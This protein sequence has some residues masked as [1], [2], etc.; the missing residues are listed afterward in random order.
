MKKELTITQ[1]Q[2]LLYGVLRI[3]FCGDI[4]NVLFSEGEVPPFNIDDLLETLPAEAQLK[5]NFDGEEHTVMSKLNIQRFNSNN[6]V[7]YDTCEPAKDG[8]HPLASPV[9]EAEEL[10]D[11]LFEMIMWTVDNYPEKINPDV[12]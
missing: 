5:V 6:K 7:W 2:Q 8:T 9:F 12:I 3:S 10:I 1:T 11:A 4:T